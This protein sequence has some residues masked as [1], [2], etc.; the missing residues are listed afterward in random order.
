MAILLSFMGFLC[1]VFDLLYFFIYDGI[2]FFGKCFV[3]CDLLS[4]KLHL[5]L[6]LRDFQS[7]LVFRFFDSIFM[8]IFLESYKWLTQLFIMFFHQ[9]TTNFD[10]TFL[11]PN[12]CLGF[13]V[14]FFGNILEYKAFLLRIIVNHILI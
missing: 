9:Q 7:I 10:Y 1:Y 11:A 2:S 3:F 13:S 14:K 6:Q 4:L 8:H 5:I 12:L